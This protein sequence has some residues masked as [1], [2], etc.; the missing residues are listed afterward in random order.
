MRRSARATAVGYLGNNAAARVARFIC[1]F[2]RPPLLRLWRRDRDA[3]SIEGNRGIVRRQAAAAPIAGLFG[4]PSAHNVI[5]FASVPMIMGGV[6]PS[7]IA[8]THGPLD[9]NLAVPTCREHQ[10]RRAWSKGRSDHFARV[11]YMTSAAQPFGP[12][13]RPYRS[14]ATVARICGIAVGPAA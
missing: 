13:I 9:R 4:N 7:F 6:S 10:V 14:A 1:T 3:R 8:T 5:T 2:A 11:F 12:A